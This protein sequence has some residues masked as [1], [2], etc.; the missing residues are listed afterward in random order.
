MT[1]TELLVWGSAIHLTVDWLFQNEWIALNKMSLRHPSAWIH[2]GLHAAG[3]AII[4]PVW[5]ALALGLVHLL[6]DTRKPLQWWSRLVSQTTAG[7]IALDVHMWRDQTLHVAT[8]AVAA[9]IVG[10]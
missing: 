9:L 5:A 2:A 8:I 1:A 4:F 6:I 3:M 10:G 7:P